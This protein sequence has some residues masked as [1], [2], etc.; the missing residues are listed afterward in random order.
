MLELIPD[1]AAQAP[2]PSW[3]RRHVVS[4]THR[5]PDRPDDPAGFFGTLA[6]CALLSVPLWAGIVLLLVREFG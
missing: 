6:V 1:I 2:R 5:E 3:W 4:D